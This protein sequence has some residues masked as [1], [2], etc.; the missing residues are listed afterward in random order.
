MNRRQWIILAAMIL[1]IAALIVAVVLD[2]DRRVIGRINGEPFCN[3]RAASA[4]EDDLARDDDVKSAEALQA[5][6]ASK[7]DAVKVCAWILSRGSE[8]SARGRATDALAQMAKEAVSARAELVIAV[9]DPDPVVRGIAIRAVGEMAP[10]VP[11][12]VPALTTRFPEGEAIQATAKFG[13][14]AAEAVPALRS[15]L[16][17]ADPAVRWQAARA[18]G[19]IGEPA[20]PALADLM[21]LAE[22]DPDPSVRE[23]A[24]EAMGDIGPAA[25]AGI[26]SL[27]KA[28]GDKVARV[29]RDAVRSLGQ[30]GPAAKAALADVR[31]ATEDPDEN[32]KKAAQGAVRLIDP[33]ETDK[34]N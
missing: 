33:S 26:P 28:L 9:T 21:R 32:V 10:D 13:P 20:L 22:S 16:K 34:K 5:L 1:I 14:A 24:A 25:A 12:A 30:M 18:L 31:R 4:W 8:P 27:V 17:Y 2:P 6:V 15:M 3:G 7:G 19:K 23:H 29:R 11:G